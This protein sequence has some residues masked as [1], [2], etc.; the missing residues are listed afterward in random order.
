LVAALQNIPA[1]DVIASFGSGSLVPAGA[2]HAHSDWLATL[3]GFPSRRKRELP[4]IR[5]AL[6]RTTW[7]ES[8]SAGVPI[9]I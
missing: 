7:R 2:S 6:Q 4:P 5:S 9:P 3:C 1:A 8:F